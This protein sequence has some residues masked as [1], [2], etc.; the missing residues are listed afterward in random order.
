M[1]LYDDLNKPSRTILTAEGGK[2]A[3]RSK[4]LIKTPSGD[5]R[6]LVPKELERLNMF[7]DNFTQFGMKKNGST[8]NIIDSKRAFLMG[9]ALVVGCVKR[10]GEQLIKFS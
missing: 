8:Y 9:N 1:N 10:I 6:R 2:S 7:P 4:H 5:S 3:S